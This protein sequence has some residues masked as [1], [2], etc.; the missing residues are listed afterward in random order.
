LPSWALHAPGTIVV[1]TGG[2]P[3]LHGEIEPMVEA[4]VE[5]DLRVV[6]GTNG[7]LL[8]E[9]RIK[10]FKALGLAG[11]GISGEFLGVLPDPLPGLPRNNVRGDG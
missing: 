8:S 9:A 4:G 10:R 7:V 5:A 3:M 1:L 6:L 11:V 2:E